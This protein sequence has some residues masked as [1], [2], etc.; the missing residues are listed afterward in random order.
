MVT[1]I[2]TGTGDEF[3]LTKAR[4]HKLVVMTTPTST[5]PTSAR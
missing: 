1:A 5:A 2:G 4:Y 3:D